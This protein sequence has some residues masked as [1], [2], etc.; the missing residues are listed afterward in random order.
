[1]EGVEKLLQDFFKESIKYFGKEIAIPSNQYFGIDKILDK[2]NENELKLAIQWG[3]PQSG[4]VCMTIKYNI[5]LQNLNFDDF[6][7]HA[8][9][10][11]D[12][13]LL[14]TFNQ[15]EQIDEVG[16]RVDFGLDMGTKKHTKIKEIEANPNAV[17]MLKSAIK[18]LQEALVL[19][20]CNIDAPVG[21]SE[22]PCCN[23]VPYPKD[24]EIRM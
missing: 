16:V 12:M 13:L 3:F 7:V 5:A 15:Q 2:K 8:P 14:G 10:K 20:E 22:I 11:D 6:S 4:A 9:P 21:S 23:C 19:G 1:M 17:N 18:D 24:I